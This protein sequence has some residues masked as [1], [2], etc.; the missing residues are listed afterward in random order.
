MMNRISQAVE[1]QE[2]SGVD[3]LRETGR[4]Q[5]RAAQPQAKAQDESLG[6]AFKNFGEQSAKMYGSYREEKKNLA[7]E[8][9][10]EIIRKLTPEQRR[11]A[12]ANGTLLYQDDPDAM[13]ALRFKS[14]RN[15]A[16]EVETEIKNKISLGEFKTSKDLVEYRK[17]RMEDKSRAYAEAAGLDF[18]DT[19]YQRGFNADILSREAAVFDLH[20][21]KLSQQTQQIA[22]MET[23]SDLGSLF[24]DEQF[25]RS[26]EAAQD[27][28]SYF[29]H[30]MG[31]GAIPTE[32]MAVGALKDALAS[33]AAQPGSDVFMAN[34]GEQ[35]LILH[36]RPM[37]VRDIVGPEVLENYQAKAAEA[38]FTR[39]RK[40]QQD[41]TFGIQNATA[42]VDPHAGLSALAGM[43]KE[44][45]KRQPGPMVTSQSEK[46]D[47][48]RATLLRR[49]QEDSNQRL[50]QM[51]KQ[52]QQDNRLAL[53]EH[54]YIQRIAGNN[55]S[56]DWRTYETDESTGKFT[57]EDA[58]NFAAQK[59]AEIDAYQIDPADKDALKLRYLQAD[60]EDGAFRKHFETLSTDAAA[61][62]QSLIIAESAE[63]TDETTSRLREFQRIYAAQPALLASLYPEQSALMERVMHMEKAGIGIETMVDAE[64]S[65]KG[66][67][68]AEKQVQAAKW[69]ELFTGSNSAVPY[70]PAG[71]RTAAK[72]IFDSEL[73]RTGDESGAKTAV[74]EWLE[75]TT[76]S[77]GSKTRTVGAVQKRTLMV[78]PQDPMSWNAGQ[79]IVHETVRRI[80]EAKPW[81]NAGDV[82]IL[83]TP[84]GLLLND[85]V[86]SL[87]LLITPEMLK[88]EHRINTLKAQESAQ[89]SRDNSA[90][91]K[92]EQYKQRQERTQGFRPEMGTI[93]EA[94]GFRDE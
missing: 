24:A 61:Q 69:E 16:F 10:N 43:E 74:N 87:N 59:M 80:A 89:E 45:Y 73:F 52:T 76:V 7:D 41:F 40:V 19:S 71:L 15:A 64:R 94:A 39:D 33:N 5:Y 28:A 22:Q 34:I 32:E 11:E 63:V 44:L 35:E 68:D 21:Q 72:T 6:R 30:N 54:K 66:L 60:P 36:G 14:G 38:Q 53:M 2:R 17:T 25:L 42:R 90:N 77:F 20:A 9:S 26:P 1:G 75:K 57:K 92:I 91:R 46:L 85:S 58:A 4:L 50:S 51:D 27:F 81:V 79:E 8:R 18:T 48:A 12:I 62:F 13:E 67:T 31:T 55:V 88:Q 82:T 83:E 29:N 70:L 86:S 49:I 93:E 65:K 78:D 47:A 37:K 84:Q 3:R 56:T 23:T